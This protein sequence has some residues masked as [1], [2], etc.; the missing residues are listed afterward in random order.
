MLNR[1]TRYAVLALPLGFP[2]ELAS[3]ITPADMQS[4]Y[5]IADFRVKLDRAF[6]EPV[7]LDSRFRLSGERLIMISSYAC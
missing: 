4:K 1:H 5:P 2:E 3:A 6:H 7:T